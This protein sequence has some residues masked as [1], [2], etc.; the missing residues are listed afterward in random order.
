[1]N[2]AKFTP[3]PYFPATATIPLASNPWRRYEY[4]TTA[5]KC[6]ASRQTIYPLPATPYAMD[7]SHES[8][9]VPRTRSHPSTP[10]Q[11][12]SSDVH[13]DRHARPN[14][15][16]TVMRSFARAIMSLTTSPRHS[17][18]LRLYDDARLARRM[19]GRLGFIGDVPWRQSCG[20]VMVV[21]R[22]C[23]LFWRSSCRSGRHTS[24]TIPLVHSHAGVWDNPCLGEN[25][26]WLPQPTDN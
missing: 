10:P 1:V 11:P 21:S 9:L 24:F 17:L 14:L 8:S 26:T 4:A 22:H 7:W 6:W 2:Y 16:N 13:D 19:R 15:K 12:Q 20:W 23:R 3:L 18:F 25:E 5:A